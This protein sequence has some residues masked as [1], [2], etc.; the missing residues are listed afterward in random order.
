MKFILAILLSSLS[1]SAMAICC[2]G[3]VPAPW[4]GSGSASQSDCLAHGNV[5]IQGNSCNGNGAGSR[6][7]CPDGSSPLFTILSPELEKRCLSVSGVIIVSSPS[8]L[9]L[10]CFRK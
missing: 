7:L 10:C 2:K 3:T 5:Y 8:R 6:D 1:F 9:K 4:N